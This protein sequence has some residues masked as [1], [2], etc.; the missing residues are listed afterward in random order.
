MFV[1]INNLIVNLV[2]MFI[3][4]GEERKAFRNRNKKR[5]K[6]RKLRDDNIRLRQDI[7][8]IKGMLSNL[9]IYGDEMERI[10][11]YSCSMK[12]LD[13]VVVKNKPVYLS[14]A[15]IAKNEGPYIKEWIEYH[16]LV[17][18]ERFYFYDNESGDN[19]KD[20]L[21]PYIDDGSVVYKYVEGYLKQVPVYQDA[22]YK[23]KDQTKWMALIDLDEF[24]V[25]M[26][27]DT[28]SEFLMDY[29]SLPG[30]GVNWLLFDSSGHDKKPTAHGGLV[31]ANYTRVHKNHD[32]EI[33]FNMSQ[34]TDRHIKSIV[35]PKRVAYITNPH[36]AFYIGNERCFSENGKQIRTSVSAYH[37]SKKIRINHYHC[38]S[39]EEYLNK[40]KIPS[41]GKNLERKFNEEMLNFTG[42]T[43][44]DYAIQRFLPRLM[45]AMGI[46]DK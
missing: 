28:V 8:E 19:T 24:I 38:K 39:R 25:P 33:I 13:D 16:K 12:P 14:I 22:I 21:K 7:E 4:D 31:T 15:C 46:K 1:K 10:M 9:A 18:V 40:L 23:Y 37:S 3:Q 5:T 29:E 2:A 41:A 30:I 45:D 36:F 35:N 6:F 42:E 11:L 43:D 32:A 17:G 20:V 26:E 44:N 34:H 27:K